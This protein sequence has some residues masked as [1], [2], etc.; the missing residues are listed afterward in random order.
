MKHE[1]QTW[2]D[3]LEW[4]HVE[5]LQQ[6]MGLLVWAVENKEPDHQAVDTLLALVVLFMPLL[7][8]P[9]PWLQCL[10]VPPTT[11]QHAPT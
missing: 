4:D 3:V 11:L 7:P 6:Q 2:M 5:L 9:C 1:Q 8:G 10:W